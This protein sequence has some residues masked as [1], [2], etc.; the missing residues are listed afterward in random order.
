MLFANVVKC[1]GLLMRLDTCVSEWVWVVQLCSRV[2]YLCSRV[3]FLHGCKWIMICF[4]FG[5]VG[6]ADDV[7][8]CLVVLDG[9]WDMGAWF[10]ACCITM[11][12]HRKSIMGIVV[13]PVIEWGFL[14]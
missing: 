7:G 14:V 5:S 11:G 13:G 6:A 10:P 2:I 3:V 9:Y 8:M 4:P 12:V 1:I